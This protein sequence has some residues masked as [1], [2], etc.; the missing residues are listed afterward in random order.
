MV[1]ELAVRLDTRIDAPPDRV[2]HALATQEAW[3]H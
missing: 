3:R 2:W 1:V